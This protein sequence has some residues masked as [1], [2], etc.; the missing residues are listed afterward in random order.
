MHNVANDHVEVELALST[1]AIFRCYSMAFLL[2][3][4]DLKGLIVS[5]SYSSME[6]VKPIRI[7]ASSELHD[8]HA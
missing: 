6:L 1:H 4:H 3:E 5:C 8:M 7:I 2:L